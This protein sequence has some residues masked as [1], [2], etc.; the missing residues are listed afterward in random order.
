MLQELV[1]TL[2]RAHFKLAKRRAAPLSKAAC[3]SSRQS[4][5]TSFCNVMSR[6]HEAAHWYVAVNGAL[7][8]IALLHIT[9]HLTATADGHIT[10]PSWVV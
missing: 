2:L 9:A 8:R 3:L 6:L 1:V 10:A 5:H 4:I 7:W